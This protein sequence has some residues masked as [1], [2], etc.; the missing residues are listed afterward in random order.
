M[1]VAEERGQAPEVGLLPG[2]E[3]VVVTL[4]E[5]EPDAQEGPRHASS[6]TFRIGQLGLLADG[7]GDE[8]RRWMIGP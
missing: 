8:V 2:L 5:I 3:R 4:G 1:N 6:Q 7:H